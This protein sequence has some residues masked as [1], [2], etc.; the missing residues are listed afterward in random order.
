VAGKES[1]LSRT[2]VGRLYH[3]P[4]LSKALDIL[5]YLQTVRSSASLDELHRHTRFS[6][7]TVYRILKTLTHRGYLAH[8]EDGRYRLVSRPSKLRFGFAGQSDQLPFSQ[9]VT[10]S[11]REAAAVVGVELLTL[12]NAYDAATALRNTDE[13]IRE[14]VD[15]A[16]EFQIDQRV[17]PIIGDRFAMAGIPLIAV[18]IPHPH[19]I[20]FGVDNYRV[21]YAA[22]ETLGQFAK[23]AWKGKVEWVLG[24]DIEEAGSMVQGRITGAFEGVRAILRGI[25]ADRFV[26]TNARGL[27]ETSA[28]RTSD[29]LRKRPKAT[30]ILIAAADD[31]SALGAVRAVERARRDAHVAIV[32]QDCIREALEEMKRPGTCLIASV[33]NDVHSY[34][35]RLIQLG[36][37]VVRGQHVAPYHYVQHRVIAAEAAEPP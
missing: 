13:L 27:H 28:A 12:D 20:F 24:L 35:A 30:G 32:G 34:G 22:G 4:V 6:K 8:L 23:K 9:A 26:R 15:L 11:L 2:G 19:A 16:I 25:P 37:A 21:G 29:F 31:T 10:S 7:T 36:L 18:E 14:R 3:I 5:E 17:A 1:F 33:S